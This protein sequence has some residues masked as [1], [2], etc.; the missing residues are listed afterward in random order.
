M[1]ENGGRRRA[2]RRPDDFGLW[3]SIGGSQINLGL[4]TSSN[5]GNPLALYGEGLRS[6]TEALKRQEGHPTAH[7]YRGNGY[8][9]RY[10]WQ[11][12][13][14]QADLEDLRR[15]VAE[16]EAAG[17]ADKRLTQFLANKVA[18]TKKEIAAEGGG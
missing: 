8:A 14:G 3:I 15:A 6:L 13:R 4:A 12:Q 17:R 1:T 11:A 18:A 5:G 2:R 10:R 7:W 9:N 16:W